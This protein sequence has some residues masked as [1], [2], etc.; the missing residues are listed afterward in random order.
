M[1][2]ID[3]SAV[4]RWADKTVIGV[5]ALPRRTS[6]PIATGVG[7]RQCDSW[8]CATSRPIGAIDYQW[9]E[10]ARS[11]KRTVAGTWA[12]CSPLDQY[13]RETGRRIALRRL[14][15][16]LRG[17][18][19]ASLTAATIRQYFENRSRGRLSAGAE[20][21]PEPED[22]LGERGRRS[23]ICPCGLALSQRRGACARVAR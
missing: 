22:I 13:C 11:W 15:A 17:T 20:N 7:R 8:K 2:Q 6:I 23:L 10:G 18:D 4:P 12:S 3:T 14:N 9:R 1:M 16:A 5:S 21:L 19:K